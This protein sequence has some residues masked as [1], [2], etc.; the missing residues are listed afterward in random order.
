M[1]LNIKIDINYFEKVEE[2]KNM[3]KN[4]TKFWFGKI[5]RRLIN[6]SVWF[7][8]KHLKKKIY[9]HLFILGV[10]IRRPNR[11]R[12]VG[13]RALKKKVLSLILRPRR[14]EVPGELTILHIEERNDLNVITHYSGEKIF[15]K[16]VQNKHCMNEAWRKIHNKPKMS[17]STQL[18]INKNGTLKIR[19]D[20]SKCLKC[21]EKR[22]HKAY[23][24][25]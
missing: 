6:G 18:A 14:D 2:F 23:K 5:N 17:Q 21:R 3:E 20:S 19:K 4:I 9:S 24:I 1:K 25:M 7:P 15:K 22:T 13:W 8:P 12:S 16:C 10:K 11:W